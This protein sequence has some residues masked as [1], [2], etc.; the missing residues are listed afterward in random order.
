MIRPILP[1]AAAL[2]ALPALFAAPALVAVPALVSGPASA[3]PTF[4]DAAGRW[5]GAGWVKRDGDASKDAVRC[6]ITSSYEAPRLSIDGKCAV[7][8]TN[9]PVKG[10]VD[11]ASGRFTGRWYNPFGADTAAVSGRRKGDTVDLR[12]Q[13]RDKDSDE[14]VD[15]TLVW[16]LGTDELVLSSAAKAPGSKAEPLSRIV[17]TR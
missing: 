10:Y 4:V 3:E 12:F 11:E 2:A 16:K 17:F 8:G 14:T 1:V 5:S 13:F 7:S 6:R 9:F 15:G